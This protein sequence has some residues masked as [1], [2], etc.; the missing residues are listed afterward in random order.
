MTATLDIDMGNTRTKW[1]CGRAV[2]SVPA[3]QLP[4]LDVYPTRVRVATVLRNKDSVAQAVH[5]RFGVQA[6]F[7][8]AS[9]Q[10]DGLICGYRDPARLGVDR[11][12]AMLAAWR[13]VRAR[14]VVVCAGTAVTVDM[15]AA[16]GQHQGGYIA[17]GL[18]LL[19]EGLE[20]ST[21]DIGRHEPGE[22]ASEDLGPGVDTSGAVGAGTLKMLVAFVESTI[23]GCGQRHDA[24][25]FVTGGDA[26]YLLA[27]LSHRATPLRHSPTL[28][29]D[30]LAA[31][32]P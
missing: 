3:P 31:A 9:R 32:L 11:W 27:H 15:V 23:G 4:D 2:G 6:E 24:A 19:R 18:R 12:L 7:A 16:S 29:L 21:A 22:L 28:V 14:A 10:L 8:T 25:V 1:R 20:R 26:R 30:G 17:P 5:T 13:R